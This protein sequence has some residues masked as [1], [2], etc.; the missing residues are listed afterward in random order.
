MTLR[1]FKEHDWAIQEFEIAQKDKELFQ[2]AC[3]AR[4][5][6]MLERNQIPKAMAEFQKGLAAPQK[7]TETDLNLR[8]FLAA[9][10][11]KTRDL[12]TAISQWE[13]IA[14]VRPSFRDVQDK[15]KSFAEFRTDDTVKDFMIASPAKFETISRQMIENLGLT[16]VDLTVD[17]DT[18]IEAI[19]TVT[20]GKW[21]N[22]KKSNQLIRIIRAT[23]AITEENIRDLHE[24]M[25]EKAATRGIMITTGDYSPGAIDFAQS[26]P[27]N[28]VEKAQVI[29]MLQ[30]VQKDMA[31]S[32]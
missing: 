28:L 2:K 3:L 7:D 5:C 29:Q 11:E 12:Y 32:K 30:A 22:T 24:N 6:S 21:R 16:I 18:Q 15:L 17:S 8:Y 13:K 23:D 4:G 26:R 10:A 25:R 14:E 9:C 31:K 1:S 20:Q 19:G 27:I